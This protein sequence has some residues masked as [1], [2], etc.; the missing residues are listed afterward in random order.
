LL[1]L[2]LVWGVFCF[3]SV[4]D[5]KVTFLP[6][7]IEHMMMGMSWQQGTATHIVSLG[8]EK[9]NAGTPSHFS[10]LFS[11]ETQPMGWCYPL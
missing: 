10:I 9:M 2:I 7:V 4:F 3:V 1:V 5:K 8:T 6:I 11:P